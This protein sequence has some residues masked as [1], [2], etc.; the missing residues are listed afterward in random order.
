MP[1]PA[2]SAQLITTNFRTFAKEQLITSSET[3]SETD[4]ILSGQDRVVSLEFLIDRQ[5]FRA[6]HKLSEMAFCSNCC[7][8][9]LTCLSHMNF[10]L[11]E[12]SF[13]RDSVCDMD[14]FDEKGVSIVSLVR[15][16]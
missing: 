2:S 5:G 6:R 8:G 15:F 13:E 10:L 3:D 12:K 4:Y 16:V 1:M 7:L 9:R 14:G 11:I